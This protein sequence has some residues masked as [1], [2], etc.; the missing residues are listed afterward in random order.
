MFQLNCV[1]FGLYT[2]PTIGVHVVSPLEGGRTCQFPA[3]VCFPFIL[4]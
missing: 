4:I 2:D 3:G 1:Y